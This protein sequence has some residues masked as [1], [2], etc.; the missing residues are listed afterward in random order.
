MSAGPSGWDRP[1]DLAKSA[2]EIPDPQ[3]T[4]VPDALRAEIEDYMARYPDPRS[5]TL[6]ALEAAQRLYGWCSP[7]ALEQVACVI[8]VTPAYLESVETV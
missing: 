8:R 3:T 6:A 1:A 7:E 4:P 5:A 2:A